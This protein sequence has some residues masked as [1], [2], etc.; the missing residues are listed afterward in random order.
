MD[1]VLSKGLP[2]N[3]MNKHGETPLHSACL[4]GND[5]AVE[6]LLV[7]GADSN[8]CTAYAFTFFTF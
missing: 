5:V 6:Y 4:R 1:L 2:V 8:L 3:I 7:H